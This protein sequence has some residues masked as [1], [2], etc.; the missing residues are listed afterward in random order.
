[1]SGMSKKEIRKDK[2]KIMDKNLENSVEAM[3]NEIRIVKLPSMRMIRSPIGNPAEPG[4]KL[5]DFYKWAVSE[6]FNNEEEYPYG[7]GRPIFSFDN[8]GFQFIIKVDDEFVNTQGWEEF[9]FA[10]GLYA[11]FSAWMPE[12]FNKFQQFNTWLE[13]SSIYKGDEDA[14]KEGRFVMSHIVTPNALQ[15]KLRNEQH[16]I[17]VPIKLK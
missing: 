5:Q 16:D 14:E 3:A 13:N 12:M 9:S 11:V 15:E 6:L 7:G 17:F 8:N 2:L 1:M 4:G 10:G